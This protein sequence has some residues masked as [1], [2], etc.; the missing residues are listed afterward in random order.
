M[1]GV[2]SP[3]R[4]RADPADLAVAGGLAVLTLASRVPLWRDY[5][6]NW[7][8]ANF[9]LAVLRFDVREHRPHPPGYFYFVGLGWLVNLGLNDPNRSLTLVSTLLSVGAVVATYLAGRTAAADRAS[10]VAAAVFL[11][12][13]VTFWAYGLV[14][15]AYP[16]LALFGAIVGLAAFVRRP[17]PATV[18]LGVGS[19]FRPDLVLLLGPLWAWSLR[20]ASW[21]RRLGAAA[22]LGV[23]VLGW[24]GPTV[25]LSGGPAEYF[26]ALG[27]YLEQDVWQRYALGARGPA[28]L[29]ANI[30]DTAAYVF[31]GLYFTA[32]PL[33][34]GL[35]RLGRD[36][37]RHRSSLRLA[38]WVVLWLGPPLAFYTLVHIGD[39]GYIFSFLPALAIVA[40]LGLAGDRR[41]FWTGLV[42][43]ALLN[44]AVFFFHPRVLTY[45]GLTAAD[46][47][48][49]ERLGLLDWFPPDSTLVVA[50]ESYRALQFYRPE[51]RVVWVDRR[52]PEGVEVGI[53]PG[54]RQLVVFDPGL[55]P[56]GA[57]RVRGRTAWVS[58]VAVRPGEVVVVGP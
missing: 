4:P 29:A 53:P 52:R 55:K 15:L 14:A 57:V 51:F 36:A 47:A 16:A 20:Q 2:G 33:A 3:V 19:G 5:L 32:V 17:L 50:A 46:A 43:V 58:V 54:I 8:A 28:A 34:A 11:L 21:R 45:P 23:L 12:T 42:A 49:G 7:D 38:A 35:L 27:A 37:R 26:Q 1:N 48:F 25:L 30:R 40:A 41:V 44:S 6:F 31:Y 10:G 24:L 56:A 18:G 22:L 9:A 39:P 13:S